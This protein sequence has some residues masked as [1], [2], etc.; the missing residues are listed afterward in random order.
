VKNKFLYDLPF[1]HN[2]DVTYDR[3]IVL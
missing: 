1:S 3:H 2:T